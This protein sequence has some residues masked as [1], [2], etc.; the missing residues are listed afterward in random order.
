MGNNSTCPIVG[1]GSVRIC[2]FDG[3][4]QTIGDVRYVIGLGRNL[5]S[6][7]SFDK[8]GH[9]SSSKGGSLKAKEILQLLSQ[10]GT[11]DWWT[12]QVEE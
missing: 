4:I 12:L 6:L 11:F 5:L 2:M 7:S 10:E 8:D 3:F 1:Y 9:G